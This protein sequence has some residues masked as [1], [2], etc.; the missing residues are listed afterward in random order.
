[1]QS[2]SGT[3]IG[4]FFV[5]FEEFKETTLSWFTLKEG[6]YK[7]FSSVHEKRPQQLV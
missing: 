6:G 5:L 7:H 4:Y 2:D 1:M 3:V